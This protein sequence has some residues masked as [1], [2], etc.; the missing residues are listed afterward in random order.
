MKC[1]Q[2][3]GCTESKYRGLEREERAEVK[4]PRRRACHTSPP[5]PC[6]SAALANPYDCIFA[7]ADRRAF[8]RDE[9]RS[10]NRSRHAAWI[11][12]QGHEPTKSGA[13][14]VG[15]RAAGLLAHGPQDALI[16]VLTHP[17]AGF[18]SEA[19]EEGAQ[20][21]DQAVLLG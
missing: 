12:A 21:G 13:G 19:I 10:A 16:E 17:E 11:R 2:E 14:C 8:L 7:L 9:D 3:D 5:P 18:M 1:K 6:Q 15:V 4:R 20:G